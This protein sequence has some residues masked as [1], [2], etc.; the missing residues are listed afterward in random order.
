MDKVTTEV[1]LNEGFSNE[2]IKETNKQ[3]DDVIISKF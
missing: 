3:I 2:E 1:H